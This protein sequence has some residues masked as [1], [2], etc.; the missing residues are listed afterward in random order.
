MGIGRV[1]G[2]PGRRYRYPSALPGSCPSVVTGGG[3][4]KERLNFPVRASNSGLH[5]AARR[6]PA[7]WEGRKMLLPPA[8]LRYIRAMNLASQFRRA[9]AVAVLV[10]GWAGTANAQGHCS[11]LKK[12]GD[13]AMEGLRYG[14]AL[15]AYENAYKCNPTPS[16]LYNQARSLEA[17]GRFPES[18]AHYLEFQ[19]Q[20]PALLL[21]KVPGLDTLIADARARVTTVTIITNTSGAHVKIRGHELGQT[22]LPEPVLLNAGLAKIEVSHTG[23]ETY[24][25]TIELPRGTDI[26]LEI[27][28]LP[29][30]A[31][32]QAPAPV[33]DQTPSS[34][35][36]PE[37]GDSGV[38][39]DSSDSLTLA[40]VAGG[41]GIAGLLAG[42]TTGLMV[43]GKKSERDDECDY[44][45][46]LCSQQGLDAHES[47]QSLA[48]MSNIGWAV[49]ALGLSVGTY[50]LL[51][52]GESS[53]TALHTSASP[54]GASTS[55]V[56]RW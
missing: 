24:L 19:S 29:T 36:A 14:D 42:V 3:I 13:D 18:L 5:G 28:L 53:N 55:L 27:S 35:S 51:T 8:R 32:T 2:K 1:L 34:S 38:S 10:T 17:L 44:G 52:S 43:S 50:F 40:Y 11:E 9:L 30:T 4:P 46:G 7:L 31:A 48:L 26:T 15:V 25:E 37:E 12:H 54:L 45:A 41:I 49:G 22:P 20:A 56:H 21:A 47:A 23:Y 6:C 33:T 39:V 16:L